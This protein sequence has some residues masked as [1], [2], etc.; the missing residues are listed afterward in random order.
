M[1]FRKWVQCPIPF[2]WT[3]WST[4]EP[5]KPLSLHFMSGSCW[6]SPAPISKYATFTIYQLYDWSIVAFRKSNDNTPICPSLY[7]G[8]QA[9]ID[10]YSCSH[11]STRLI[12]LSDWSRLWEQCDAVV[13]FLSFYPSYHPHCAWLWCCQ[14]VS[15]MLLLV[16][17]MRPQLDCR[18]S[19]IADTKQSSGSQRISR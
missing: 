9:S 2:W 3:L 10:S 5:H 12:S 14:H 8:S 1:T 18:A 11:W 13:T 17:L 4:L 16:L 19:C 6:A 15:G 7:S